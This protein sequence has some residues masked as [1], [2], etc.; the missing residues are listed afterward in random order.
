M[1]NSKYCGKISGALPKRVL[2]TTSHGKGWDACLHSYSVILYC[3][4]T[5][6]VDV[7]SWLNYFSV[8]YKVKSMSLTVTL[9][10]YRTADTSME[11]PS[12]DYVMSG[13]FGTVG[14]L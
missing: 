6:Y 14:K 4:G 10:N 13:Y 3:Y 12:A 1:H 5:Y 7:L 9:K 2:E 8:V 11:I